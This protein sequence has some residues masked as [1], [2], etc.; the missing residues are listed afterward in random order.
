MRS[1]ESLEPGNEVGVMAPSSS[2]AV[3]CHEW[4]GFRQGLAFCFQI[5]GQILVSGIDAGV[6]EPIGN[7]AWVVAGTQQIKGCAVSKTVRMQSLVFQ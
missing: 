4:R 1:L 7:G 5:E 2:F 3:R 6:A